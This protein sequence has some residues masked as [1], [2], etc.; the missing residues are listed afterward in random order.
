MKNYAFMEKIIKFPTKHFNL[1]DFICKDNQILSE[2]F[3]YLI[4]M[5]TAKVSQSDEVKAIILTMHKFI[6]IKDSMQ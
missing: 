5:E 4:L 2:K 3:A 6:E 1:I